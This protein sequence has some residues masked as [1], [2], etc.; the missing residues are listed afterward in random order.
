MLIWLLVRFCRAK[1]KKYFT[2]FLNNFLLIDL[3]M[4]NCFK[5]FHLWLFA[6]FLASFLLLVPLPR[7]LVVQRWQ[8]ASKQNNAM[9]WSG[10]QIMPSDVA[11]TRCCGVARQWQINFKFRKLRD[12]QRK[13]MNKHIYTCEKVMKLKEW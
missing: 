9:S 8:A 13:R 1:P 2:I 3:I 6:N 7:K 4:K 12:V 10:K 11:G 5:M